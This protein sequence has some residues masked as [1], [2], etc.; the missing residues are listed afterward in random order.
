M[1]LT[2]KNIR[3]KEFPNSPTLTRISGV[4]VNDK[5]DLIQMTNFW[6]KIV[7]EVSIKE[8]SPRWD[9][10]NN[11][12]NNELNPCLNLW[13]RMYIWH[14]GTANPCDFDYKSFLKTGDVN[15]EKITTPNIV[16]NINVPTLLLI[17]E[18]GSTTASISSFKKLKH[19]KQVE[20]IRGGS[21]FFPMEQP[22][23]LI[24]LIKGFKFH[25]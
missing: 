15:T 4:K 18:F 2:D 1:S 16:K 20:R 3:E 23:K 21:H 17:A 10:Y 13:Y 22:D 7:D 14:D 24:S 12:K 8:A 9:T 19:L 5:Q 25:S 6:S 11:D